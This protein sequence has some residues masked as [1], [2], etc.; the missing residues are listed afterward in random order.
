[1]PETAVLIG[2]DWGSSSVRA[3]LIDRGGNVVGAERLDAGVRKARGPACE[4]VFDVLLG[5]WSAAVERLPVLLTGMVGSAQGWREAP[6]VSA[7]AGLADVAQELVEAPRP[8]AW[9]VPGVSGQAVS[10]AP[11][12]MRG[13][14]TQLFG[15]DG[16]G[17]VLLP[18][19]HTKWAEL[20]D[21]QVTRFTTCLTGEIFELLRNPGLIGTVMAGST[22]DEAAF[23]RG[24]TDLGGPGGLLHHLFTIRSRVLLGDLQAEEAWSYASALLIGSEV[25]AMVEARPLP[26]VVRVI[27]TE[28]LAQLYR[29]ALK[30]HGVEAH[31]VSGLDASVRG[32]LRLAMA[33]GLVDE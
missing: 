32:L 11:D 5:R 9:I 7:P 27:G 12:V 18:G 17:P 24:L 33:A 16:D 15:L 29:L 23:E 21:G 26:G 30:R 14:E 31:C 4:Q 8:G 3:T 2:V 10:G 1:M 25:A 6:Y 22:L 28:D 13:E 19:T 20:E